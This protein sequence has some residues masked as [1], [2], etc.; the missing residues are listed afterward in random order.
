MILTSTTLPG[1]FSS[2][3]S[4][5]LQFIPWRSAALGYRVGFHYIFLFSKF[6]LLHSFSFGLKDFPK[7]VFH[8]EATAPLPG[9]DVPLNHLL[10]CVLARLLFLRFGMQTLYL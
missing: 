5:L 6:F 8:A 4:L 9:P 10:F 1:H 2:S 3:H 7:I